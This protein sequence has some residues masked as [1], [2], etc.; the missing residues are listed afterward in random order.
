[1]AKETIPGESIAPKGDRDDP[2]DGVEWETLN[3]GL[4]TAWDFERVPVMT[5]Y[6]HD[7]QMVETDDPQNP[8]QTRESVAFRFTIP[9]KDDIVFVWGSATLEMAFLD[10]DGESKVRAGDPVRIT[11]LGRESFSGKNGPQQIKRYRVQVAKV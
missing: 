6:Y 9:G 5:G 1:M 7:S 10:K 2:F 4:G 3:T 11:Y 8:G